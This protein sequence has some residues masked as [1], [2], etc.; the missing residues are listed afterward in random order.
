MKKIPGLLLILSLAVVAGCQKSAPA[1]LSEINAHVVDG[2]DP[3]VDG[4]GI[5]IRLDATHE[6][7]VPINLPAEYQQKGINAS[8]ALKVVNTGGVK[9]L[10]DPGADCR[11]V[12]IVS[13]RKL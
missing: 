12:Y 4:M 3:A 2:G 6:N 8:V 11:I 7:V 5:Y 1:N 13:I 10:G 9:R